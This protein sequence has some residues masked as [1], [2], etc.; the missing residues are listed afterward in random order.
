[1]WL[2]QLLML[3]SCK[4]QACKEE[5]ESTLGKCFSVRERYFVGLQVNPWLNK[6]HKGGEATHC[7]L[8]CVMIMRVRMR[9][10][11]MAP[12]QWLL[13]LRTIHLIYAQGLSSGPFNSLDDDLG[14]FGV[15][16]QLEFK[17]LES[18]CGCRVMITSKKRERK[19]M[20]AEIH[21]LKLKVKTAPFPIARSEQFC[22]LKEI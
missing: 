13:T 20:I 5:K 6:Q 22:S 16:F 9:S 7:R 2:T 3:Q 8:P 14:L 19:L 15:F 12:K 17:S 4:L 1:M 21:F 18:K 11:R 10:H